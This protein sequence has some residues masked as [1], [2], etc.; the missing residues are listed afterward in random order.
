MKIGFL[1]G[2][3]DPIHYGHLVAAQDAFEQHKLD[4]LILVPAAQAPLKPRDA[5]CPAADRLAMVRA[6]VGWDTR[7]E[8]SDYEL[9]K[10]GISYTIDTA[11]HFRKQFP[12]DQLHWIIGGDQLPRLHLWREIGELAK[13]VEFIFLERPGHPAKTH[14]PVP[15]LRLHRCDG[16]L[17][18]I[19]STELRA[20]V[21]GGLSLNY[22]V[23]HKT[24]ELIREKNLYR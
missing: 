6:A 8:V 5:Q 13:L 16:H 22:L 18:E 21:R 7:F 24:I 19:S 1:G 10:G 2:S 3:F 15:G 17:I 11:R 14:T 23:P 4:R 9:L 20:R 12:D